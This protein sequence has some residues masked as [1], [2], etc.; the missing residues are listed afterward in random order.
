MDDNNIIFGNNMT[1]RN[2]HTI[3]IINLNYVS[4]NNTID[5]EVPLSSTCKNL[6][7]ILT[8]I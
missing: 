1:K 8:S 3:Q 2:G 6:R 7:A 4:A 5:V